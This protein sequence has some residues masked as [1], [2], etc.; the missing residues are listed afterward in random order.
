MII[1]L[2]ASFM[3]LAFWAGIMTEIN[4]APQPGENIA[5][6]HV[7]HSNLTSNYALTR[8]SLDNIQL[9]DGKYATSSCMWLNKQTVG[10]SGVDKLILTFDLGK[11]Q[12]ISGLSY[13][14]AAG[15]AGVKFPTA[16]QVSVGPSLKKMYDIGNLITLSGK[17]L[18]NTQYNATKLVIKN[19]KT[20]GRYVR[21][22]ILDARY[23]FIDEI[24]IYAGKPEWT[25][26]GYAAEPA[27]DM[28]QPEGVA[29][30]R[31]RQRL[32]HDVKTIKK[33]IDKSTL[34]IEQ[35]DKFN[36]QL[37][38]LNIAAHKFKLPGNIADFKAIIPFSPIQEKL[39][40]MHAAI[41][42]HQGFAP[43]TIWH[44]YRYAPLSIWE[45]PNKAKLPT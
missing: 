24:E 6:N 13:S 2:L 45:Q 26:F 17:K 36:R 28:S 27:I 33:L 35:K 34:S 38:K 39:L 5:K 16:I 19:L 37:I 41:L 22:T 43:L 12:A 1:R 14:T 42:R 40:A 3:F 25:K 31:V 23:V 29:L 21:F 8:D 9:T 32:D 4:A 7:F 18:N 11:D 30:F 20:H 10:W 15:S 44:K